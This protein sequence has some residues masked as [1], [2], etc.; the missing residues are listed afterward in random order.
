MN[1]SF[2]WWFSESFCGSYVFVWKSIQDY[3][4]TE[5]FHNKIWRGYDA[6]LGHGH[7]HAK[8]IHV[9]LFAWLRIWSAAAIYD[10]W[11]L[12]VGMHWVRT[13]LIQILSWSQCI[14]IKFNIG[15]FNLAGLIFKPKAVKTPANLGP[16]IIFIFDV[17]SMPRH[18]RK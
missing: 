4:H 10:I 16:L 11:L 15:P 13:A 6:N 7:R 3:K 17:I 18:F 1:V 9:S 8:S 14:S 5:L 2:F 12:V